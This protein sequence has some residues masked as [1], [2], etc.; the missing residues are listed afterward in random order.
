[1][2]ELAMNGGKPVCP[3]G[4]IPAW[5]ECGAEE[6]AAMERVLESR[7]WW[8][9]T[10]SEVE[11]FE[12]E[13]AEF[14]ECRHAL[15][16]S[17]GTQALEIGLF[18]LDIGF[19]DEVIVPAFTFVATAT[20][21]LSVGAVPVPVDVDLN[22]YC[23]DVDAARR[24]VTP[25]TKA[26]VAVHLAGQPC[27]MDSLLALSRETGVEIFSD[28]AHAHGARWN[29]ISLPKLTR[30]SMYSFQNMKLLAAGE[31]GALLTDDEEIARRAWLRHTYGRPKGDKK[32]EHLDLG[33][34]CR[35][36]E[37]Q[38][39]VLRPQLARFNFMLRVREEGARRL[40]ALLDGIEG[41]YLA[42]RHPSVSVHS[43]YMYMVRID[44]EKL[45]V[46]RGFLVQAL[47]A[48]GVPAYRSY[49][50]IPDLDMF[51]R[52]SLWNGDIPPHLQTANIREAIHRQSVPNSLEISRNSIWLHHSV[53][54]GAEMVQQKVAE[55]FRKVLAHRM[56]LDRYSSVSV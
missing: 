9:G 6:K 50:A 12:R 17:N 56:A 47:S 28:S 8:R 15:A 30:N 36:T 49:P 2:S 44:P 41:L 37:F 53:L 29:G 21:V 14:H 25:K 4:T 38:A 31:G 43:H 54:M 35:M 13:F 1:M 48:E 10:G 55:A 51:N 45:G 24:A 22:T 39:A 32:Y 3:P 5:P 16:V 23:L 42:A 40:D 34:N 27:D 20:A 46:E 11:Q 52:S 7:N 33:T 19:G 26:I 18:C